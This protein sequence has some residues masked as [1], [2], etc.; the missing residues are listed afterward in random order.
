M[1]SKRGQAGGAAALVAIIGGLI[2]LY[3]LFLPPSER[4]ELLGE[5]NTVENG[6]ISDELGNLTLLSKQ[7]GSLDYLKKDSYEHDL[8]NFVLYSSTEANV[9]EEINSVNIRRNL[10]RKEFINLSFKIIEPEN[11]ENLLLSFS[12]PIRR[13]N[14]IIYLNGNL[15]ADRVIKNQN[16][17]PITLPKKYI[18]VDNVLSFEVSGPGALFWVTN[19]YNLENVMVTADITDISGLESKQY[20]YIS[21]EEKDNLEEAKLKFV[22]DCQI[23]KVGPLEISLNNEILSSI[24]P[25]CG[26]L[27]TIVIDKRRILD[28]ENKLIFKTNKGNYAIYSINVETELNEPIYPI[29]YFEI[30]DEQ[31]R[32]IENDSIDVNLTILFSNDVD[33]KDVAIKI[34]NH[35]FE[36]YTRD[37]KYDRLIDSYIRK[38]NNAFEF[39]RLRT[40][41]NILELKIRLVE[42]D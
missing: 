9:I 2:L 32:Q 40:K 14:L 33:L 28:G 20:F 34:N 31:Y 3:I 36:I 35:E 17:T 38:G 1:T 12:A 22:A 16:P 30:D 19:Q 6:E 7:P 42:K 25:D 5:N 39:V 37:L 15:I 11:T 4:A 21:E 29:Y 23:N 26:I 27:N 18:G 8:Q 10:F 41:L 13:G 24:I